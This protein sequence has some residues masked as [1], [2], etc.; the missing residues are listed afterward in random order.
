[1]NGLPYYKAYPRDFFDGTVGM[2]F[3]VKA[4]YRLLL[5]MIYM[6]GG[7]LADDPRWISGQLGCSVKKWNGLR[8]AVLS[9]GKVIALDGYLGNL[10]ADKELH[11]LKSFQDVQRKNG[12][13]PKKINSLAKA[14]AEPPLSHTEPDTDTEEEREAKASPKKRATRLPDEWFLPMEWGQWC[15]SEG[16]A[17]D[18]I[19]READ[20]FR[21]YWHAKSGANATKL[22]WL[23]TWR[24]WMRKIP[25]SNGVSNGNG[26]QQGKVRDVIAAAAF[27][28]SG[29]DWFQSESNPRRVLG[30][31]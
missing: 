6:H 17:Q 31:G 12:S 27:G 30:R 22:D 29:D 23:A 8:A 9:T 19:R 20:N 26:S 3:E 21:D 7:R 11:S 1:M 15:L 18:V 5:D 25:K 2:D 13:Q 24:V 14:M 28:T 10:R 4:A 16:Y